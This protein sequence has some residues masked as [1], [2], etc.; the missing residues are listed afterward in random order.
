MIVRCLYFLFVSSFLILAIGAC[1]LKEK[2][3]SYSK[4]D[5]SLISTEANRF[6][7][8]VFDK[9]VDR[10]PMFQTY[11]GIKKDY[12]KWDELTEANDKKELEI[13][14]QE[15]QYLLDS[16]P[17]DAL[18]RQTKISYKLFKLNAENEINDF[19]FRLYDYPVN[20]MFGL[21]SQVPAFLI[22]MHQI[23]DTSDALAYLSRLEGVS[24]LFD[25]LIEQLRLREE[26]GVVPP[27]F[28]YKYVID[29][30]R[31][32]LK[33]LPFESGKESTLLAD[34]RGKVDALSISKLDKRKLLDSCEAKLLSHIKPSFE[35]LIKFTES[36]EK[37]AT[38]DDGV[39][40]FENGAT[41]YNMKLTRTT[42][43]DMT[44]E[45]I[46]EIGLRE[47]DRIH[48]QM[49]EIMKRVKFEGDLHGF[50]AFVKEDERFYYPNTDE[51][52]KLYLDSAVSLIEAME[53]RLDELF[54]TKPKASIVVKRVEPFREKSAGTAFYQSPAPDG[55]RPGTYYANLYDMRNMAKYEMEALAYH[56]GIPGHHMDRSISQELTGIPKFRKFGG[57]TAYVEGWGLYSEFL[58]K[59]MGMYQDPYADYGRL[60]MELWRACRL[61]V[62]TGIHSKKWTREEGIAY[63]Q[64]NT[65]A[66]ERD[67]IRMVERHIV[68]PG[69]ATA[70]KVGMLKILDLREKAK[71]ELG[72]DFD[73]R[74][75]HDVVLTSGAVPLYILSELVTEWVASKKAY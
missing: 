72:K 57:Y 67:C 35:K 30:A 68:M 26:I 28:V 71:S 3:E 38:T 9:R 2:N 6:F 33:G 4:E 14:K 51:G 40:K 54:I 5:I 31:N 55:S 74:E 61:V 1:E 49:K 66:T 50:F 47:V 64:N 53:R 24:T 34:F 27:K 46:H 8:S 65:S 13:T 22:N 15:L 10:S 16:I 7:D 69:Q 18:D 32:I 56:E 39:W 52:R 25:Q 21:H 44:A 17:Y 42:T 75:F 37:R 48:D 20:Q 11:L 58:P 23:S 19:E 62:D 60:A 63:Y 70:Y 45:E 41:Y 36:Q 59:E 43:T 29:D 12:G 73:I